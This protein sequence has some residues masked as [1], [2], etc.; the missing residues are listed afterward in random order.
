M[1]T[2]NYIPT[3]LALII[4]VIVSGQTQ[5]THRSLYVIGGK[6]ANSTVSGQ[7]PNNI[8]K[9]DKVYPT[10][11]STEENK[12]PVSVKKSNPVQTNFQSGEIKNQVQAIDN[13]TFNYY[14]N[15]NCYST[16]VYASELLKQADG[17]LAIE[18]NLRNELKTKHGNEKIQLIN[19]ANELLKQAEVKQIQASE[20]TGKINVEKFKENNI[21]L[22][23]LI[24][25]SKID[26][27]ITVAANDL[28]TEAKYSMKMAQEM[29]EEAYAMKN[30][31]S[32]LGTMNNAEEKEVAALS[33]QEAAISLIKNATAS[34]D[35]I[36]TNDLA[37]K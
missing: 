31:A 25:K 23:T 8:A 3:L 14:N 32:K 2:R 22:Y 21:T 5:A 18:R 20:I 26:T 35:R 29:R 37:V 7:K 27:Q 30:N 9:K 17:L 10:L 12:T 34:N 11:V 6:D 15:A 33:K 36:I 16:M 24:D 1:K 4:H 28:N 13:N 19:S